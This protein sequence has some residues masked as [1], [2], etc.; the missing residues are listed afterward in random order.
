MKAGGR[1]GAAKNAM[2]EGSSWTMPQR[3]E[4]DEWR[5]WFSLVSGVDWLSDSQLN[6][7]GGMLG[8]SCW[9]RLASR[10]ANEAVRMIG[11][12]NPKHFQ[13]TK[14]KNKKKLRPHA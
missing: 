7:H 3:Q 2:P 14:D 13:K 4:L 6:E 1:P 11:H 10:P 12:L 9:F 5:V 8:C